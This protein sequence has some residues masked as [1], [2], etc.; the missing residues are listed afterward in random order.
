MYSLFK[1]TFSHVLV[2]TTRENNKLYD[3]ALKFNK[4]KGLRE[5]KYFYRNKKRQYFDDIMNDM[6]G[7]MIPKPKNNGGEQG[8][9]INGNF[10]GLFFSAYMDIRTNRPQQYSFFGPTRFNVQAEVLFTKNCNLYFVD[11][12]CHYKKHHMAVILT[13]KSSCHNTFCSK[14]LRQL[15]IYNNPFL[16]LCKKDGS[17]VVMANMGMIVEVY[18]TETVNI[19]TILEN[20]LGCIEEIDVVGRGYVLPQGIQKRASCK[21]CN[22]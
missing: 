9:V 12:Y 13:P 20:G 19:N 17:R 7:V 10:R 11:F 2:L 16:K 6:D 21:I 4:P 15:D 18:Y 14:Y 22:L 3:L 8:S 5:I 1:Q